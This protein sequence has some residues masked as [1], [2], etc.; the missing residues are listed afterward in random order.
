M[1]RYAIVKAMKSRNN[2][3]VARI[4]AKI[5]PILKSAGVRRASVFGSAA[6]GEPAPR[7]VDVL[8]EMP[9]SYGLFTFLALKGELEDCLGEKVDLVEYSHIKPSLKDY[10]FRDEVRIL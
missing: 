1:P 7:D 3:T 5:L 2:S 4:K 10:I 9:K 8:V 6:R